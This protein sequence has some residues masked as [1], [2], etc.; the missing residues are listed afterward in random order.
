MCNIKS[1]VQLASEVVPQDTLL[2]EIPNDII[3]L[4]K[5]YRARIVTCVHSSM[6]TI[7]RNKVNGRVTYTCGCIEG[8]HNNIHVTTILKCEH[9]RNK[10]MS[11][12][13]VWGTGWCECGGSV[14]ENVECSI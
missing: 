2:K 1:L 3:I 14:Q 12:C 7:K 8:W 11:N 4:I 13:S 10:S 5:Y 6:W 9:R